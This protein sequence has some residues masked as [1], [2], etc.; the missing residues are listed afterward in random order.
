MANFGTAPLG[1]FFIST[2][3]FCLQSLNVASLLLQFAF[4]SKLH[5]LIIRI[6]QNFILAILPPL[7]II[8]NAIKAPASETE[9]FL[10]IWIKN[11]IK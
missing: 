10:K 4:S 8:N 9:I 1:Q 2:G 3:F 6:P 11:A 7:F 5:C